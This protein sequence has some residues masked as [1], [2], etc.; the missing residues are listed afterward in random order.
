MNKLFIPLLVVATFAS[1]KIYD[2]VAVVVE[3]KAITLYEIQKLMQ[4]QHLDAKHASEFLIRQKLE[5]GL[6]QQKKISVSEDE[7]YADIKQMAQRNHLS[8]GEFYD[9]VRESNG[10]SSAELKK[11]I[12]EKL[13]RQK[14]YSS[15]AMQRMGGEPSD[16]ELHDF[17]ELHKKEFRH[18]ESFEVIIYE[19]NQK[20][21]LQAKVMNPMIYDPSIAQN[22]Q[23]LPF[24]RISPELASLL[25]KTPPYHFT[26]I[27]PNGKGGFITFYVQKVTQSQGDHFETVRNQVL[28]ALMN[29]KREK[30]LSDYFARMK[31]N[32]DINII[33]LP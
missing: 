30:I 20:Q 8:I 26:P 6:I 17:Y 13:L 1:A 10:L 5:D 29:E 21:K 15:I 7:V 16:E 14:L 3:N 9:A 33:R 12:K 18:P 2:G 25:E 31:D 27:V 23:V 4:E 24:D 22:T 19:S 32:S 11:K 28:N